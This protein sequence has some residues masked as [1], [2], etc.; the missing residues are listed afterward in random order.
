MK[1]GFSYW[2]MLILEE[3][4][5]MDVLLDE[6]SREETVVERGTPLDFDNLTQRWQV[7]L[8]S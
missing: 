7:S 6:M 3:H 5:L 1:V 2:K 8:C 4:D